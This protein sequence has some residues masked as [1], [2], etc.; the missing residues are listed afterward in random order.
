MNNIREVH[1]Y[2]GGVTHYVDTTEP[3][4]PGVPPERAPALCAMRP[5]WPGIWVTSEGQFPICKTCEAINK[6]AN[7]SVGSA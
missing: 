2:T 5:L 3:R 1:L 4:S 6:G 7:S